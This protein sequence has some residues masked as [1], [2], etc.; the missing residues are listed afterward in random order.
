MITNIIYSFEMK[1]INLDPD[2]VYFITVGILCLLGC[3][4]AKNID[5]LIIILATSL[6]GA[7][8]F[9]RV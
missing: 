5:K 9:V 1:F 2:T 8:L 7:Y 3:I 6:I 4:I